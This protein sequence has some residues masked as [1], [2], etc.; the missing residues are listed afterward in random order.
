L[1]N[2]SLMWQRHIKYST[3]SGRATTNRIVGKCESRTAK[4]IVRLLGFGWIS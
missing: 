1:L 3:S 2:V 4:L